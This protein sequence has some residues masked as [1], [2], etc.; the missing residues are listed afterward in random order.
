[1]ESYRTIIHVI[2][3]DLGEMDIEIFLLAGANSNLSCRP[4]AGWMD[5]SRAEVGLK[6]CS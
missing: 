4:S 1:M 6:L 2:F 3:K 5:L